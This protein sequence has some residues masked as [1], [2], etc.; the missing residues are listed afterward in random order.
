[1]PASPVKTD[2]STQTKYDKYAICVRIENITILR[3]EIKTL[4]LSQNKDITNSMAHEVVLASP[5]KNKYFIG[6]STAHFWDLYY[7]LGPTKFNLT[8]SDE[9]KGYGKKLN[10]SICFQ[11]F[12]TLLS[13]RRGFNILT[14]AHWYGVSEYSIRTVFTT[15]IMFFITLRTTDISCF[16]NNKNSKILY[17]SYFLLLNTSA[18]QLTVQSLNVKYH[19]STANR[20]I[21]RYSSYKSHCTAEFLI[22]VSPNGAACFISDLFEGSITDVD[23]FDQCGIL[24]QISPGDAL[25]VD[26]GLTIQHLLLTKQTTIS[27]PPFLRKRDAFTKEEV[28]LTKRIAK[29]RIHVERFNECLKNLEFLIV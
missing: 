7:F 19:A 1:M 25:L 9:L 3:T 5:E 15:W 4:K 17:Q 13:L 10:N 2:K 22:T 26:K 29:A 23:V 18:L 27:I 11:L 8:Y 14:I 24:Q 16:L 6:L 12:I 28:M 20:E 21:F